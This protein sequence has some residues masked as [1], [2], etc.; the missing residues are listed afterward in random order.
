MKVFRIN[1]YFMNI[2]VERKI[3]KLY[4]K[5]VQACNVKR[6]LTVSIDFERNVL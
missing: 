5:V 4:V 1:L 6:G 2:A 3:S